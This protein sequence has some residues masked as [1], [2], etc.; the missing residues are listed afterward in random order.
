MAPPPTPDYVLK[1]V[2]SKRAVWDFGGDPSNP[3]FIEVA[4]DT[5]AGPGEKI[6]EIPLNL[7][8]VASDGVIGILSLIDIHVMPFG[9]G[10]D[11]RS[12]TW[13]IDDGSF[14]QDASTGHV[15][16]TLLNYSA[17]QAGDPGKYYIAVNRKT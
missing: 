5:G 12:S 14:I 15:F 10:L 2:N 3:T 6:I 9:V 16:F 7:P 11:G 17:Y 13:A 8:R 1:Q 4:V